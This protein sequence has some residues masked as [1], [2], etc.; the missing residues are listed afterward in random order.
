MSIRKKILS[1]FILVFVVGLFL[2]IC[3][4]V[5]TRILTSLS[6]DQYELQKASAGVSEVL[7]AHYTWR[8]GLTE[9]VLAG[10]DFTGSLDPN[11]CALG[12]WKNSKEAQDITDPEILSLLQQLDSPHTFIHN[13]A[14]TLLEMMAAGNSSGAR[15]DLQGS[16]LPETGN[17]IS[18]LTAMAERYE[19]LLAEKST[20]IIG[21]GSLFTA[22]I[23]AL[24]LVAAVAC[25]L[26]AWKITAS[27]M[28]PIRQVTN[29]AETISTG[30][31]DVH[32]EYAVNDEIGR[33]TA[34][35]Q[36]LAEATRNQVAVAEALAD[37][38]L[39][40]EVTSRS[41]KDAMNIALKKMVENLNDMFGQISG[42]SEQ[43]SSGSKQIAD[44]AQMLAQGAT[45]QAATVEQLSGAIS[46]VA[47]KTRDNTALADK[48]AAL[49]QSIKQNAEKGSDQMSRMTQAVT[50]INEAS[51]SISKVIKTI[52]DI[53]FQTNI[54]ALNAAVEAARAGQHGKGFAVVADEVRN[55]AAKSA[56]AAKDTG[57]LIVNAMEKAELG[58]RISNETAASLG[59]IVSGINESGQIVGRIA[60]ASNEQNAAISEINK[61]IEQVAQVVQQNS[62]TAEESA[63]ASEEMSSQSELLLGLVL[64]FKLKGR[65]RQQ[66]LPK[67][68]ASSSAFALSW[69]SDEKY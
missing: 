56:D 4:L 55:L 15:S 44:G 11:S 3:G 63:A 5:S 60:K 28:T 12:Q 19:V 42:S 67:G 16:V 40:M 61:G 54:L 17:V 34:S 65:G 59:E 35:F 6:D 68:S 18:A 58:A 10:Q 32:I 39:T 69:T 47:N 33:L 29:A 57:V 30:D 26:I 25:V 46:E 49:S 31:L 38:D 13:E 52:E 2:G 27:I 53:A 20:D 41:E 14:K 45:E 8:Q 43:V 62:A 9:A 66:A 23:I 7:N 50:E 1:G 64:K 21:T 24:L 22:I 51:Q 36:K 48:A 37:G